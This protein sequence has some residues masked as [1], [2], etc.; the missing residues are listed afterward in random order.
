VIAHLDFTHLGTLFAIN[1]KLD[2]RFTLT[3]L[4]QFAEFCDAR[5]KMFPAYEFV[6]WSS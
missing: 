1:S 6:V 2:G 5:R 4:V 3:E